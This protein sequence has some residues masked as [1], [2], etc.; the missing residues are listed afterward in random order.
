[1]ESGNKE[2]FKIL[3]EEGADPSKR[4]RAG[5]SVLNLIAKRCWVDWAEMCITVPNDMTEEKKKAF[6]NQTSFNGRYID[7]PDLRK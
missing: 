5:N 6:A 7:Y 3:L 1:M 4:N 2:A